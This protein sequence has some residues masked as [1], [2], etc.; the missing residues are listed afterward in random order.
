MVRL[1]R[2]SLLAAS[3]ALAFAPAARA[4]T[5]STP[6]PVIRQAGGALDPMVT[7][8]LSA[9]GDLKYPHDFPH[10][11]Y[12]N[13]QAPKGGIFSESVTAFG[14]PNGNFNTFNSFNGWILKGDGAAGLERITVSLMRA[15]AD[16][17]D[18]MYGFLA[19][20]VAIAGDGATHTFTLRDTARFHDGTNITASDVA[21]SLM[22]MKEQGH[23]GI[24]LR[25][26]DLHGAEAA[27]ARTLVVRYAPKRSRDL[28]L[29]VAGL[30]VFSKAYYTARP[31]GESTLDLPMGCGPYRVARFEAGRFIEYERVKDWWGESLPVMRGQS[32]FDTLR[33][34]YFR[35]RDVGFEGFKGRTYLFREEFTS[36]TWA[37]GYDFPAVRD[38]RVKRET[39]PDE[40]PSGAQGWFIN[41]RREKFA[42]R[43][44]REALSFAFDFEWTNRNLMFDSFQRT[45]SFFQSSDMMATGK[46]GADELALLEPFRGKV[47]DEVFGEPFVP[48]VSDGSGQDRNLLRRATQLLR[49]AGW[50]LR[51]GR[52]VNARGEQLTIEFLD[53]EGALERHT[54]PFI[55]NLKRLGIEA[56][57]RVVD[58]AQYQRRV[59]DYDFD[60]TVRRLS[61]SLTP[62]ENL[63]PF[64]SSEAGKRPG[65]QNLAGVDDPVVDALIERIIAAPD[66]ESL[67][68]ACRAFDRVVRAGRYWVPHWYKGSHWIAYWDA[69]AR[70]DTKPRYGR[71][72]PDTWWFDAA[73]ARQ[74]G[75]I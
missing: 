51:E 1:S 63:R 62:G 43:R 75:V 67:T 23:P 16:E 4:A 5:S 45:H 57:F 49:E 56:N 55:A 66:R 34:E 9:F 68:L 53:G 10:F 36:R 30:P 33:Y 44:L 19:Q 71:G 18:A 3:A 73:K 6:G 32:N 25:L 65:S 54:A 14:I 59:I 7:H 29:L 40:T 27:D 26:R 72:F 38:G 2:R 11:D 58:A 13:P 42:D 60:M 52:L 47:P 61:A 70:P 12:V 20:S 24:A 35:D 17:P 48:P 15:S 21:F 31:F 64:F 46:P 37:T 41:T 22:V 28:P 74:A 8:G 39:L 50:S 69:Y